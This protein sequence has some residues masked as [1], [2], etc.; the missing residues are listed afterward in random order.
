M[1]IIRISCGGVD[2]KWTGIG[3]KDGIGEGKTGFGQNDAVKWYKE[4]ETPGIA[5]NQQVF[6]QIPF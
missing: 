6:R 4:W 1:I 3:S 2:E 5:W